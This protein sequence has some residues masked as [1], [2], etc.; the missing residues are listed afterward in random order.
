M[1]IWQQN[2]TAQIHGQKKK[3]KKQNPKKKKIQR[4]KLSK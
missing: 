1:K 3:K 4:K 2:H